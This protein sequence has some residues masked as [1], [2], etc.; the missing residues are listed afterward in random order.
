[1]ECCTI[2]RFRG[3]SGLPFATGLAA[4]NFEVLNR[5]LQNFSVLGNVFEDNTE[6]LR[7]TAETSNPHPVPLRVRFQVEGNLIR[8]FGPSGTA[9]Q[10]GIVIRVGAGGEVKHNLIA[11]HNY[12]GPDL[13]FS[14]GIDAQ[15]L[16]VA[17]L[18]IH[19]VENV[20]QDNQV[21][22]VS[23][24]ATG[25][26]FVENTFE[27]PGTGTFNIGIAS[28]GSGDR[29]ITNRFRNLT[30][31]VFLVGDDPIFGTTLGIASDTLSGRQPSSSSRRAEI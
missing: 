21:H 26:Q 10:T 7:L 4:G 16:G 11:G 5:P 6:S 29:I 17:L 22:L 27:G 8:G 28:S 20:F 25:A 9:T 24:F 23:F 14:F 30:S 13:R 31:G 19:Y 15:G 2:R 18:A 12:T 1:V 3:E